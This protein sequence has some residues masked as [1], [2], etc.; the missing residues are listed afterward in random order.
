MT[1]GSAADVDVKAAAKP[2]NLLLFRDRNMTAPTASQF[3]AEWPMIGR[4]G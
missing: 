4:D 1:N 2:Q 3:S